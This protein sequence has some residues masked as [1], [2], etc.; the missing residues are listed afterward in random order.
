MGCVPEINRSFVRLR[1]GG[2][3]L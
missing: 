3:F 2:T 1:P